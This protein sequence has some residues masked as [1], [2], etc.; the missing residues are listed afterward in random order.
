LDTYTTASPALDQTQ[1]TKEQ[2]TGFEGIVVSFLI[3]GNRFYTRGMRIKEEAINNAAVE[4]DWRNVKH[5][6][7][8]SYQSI[9]RV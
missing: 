1:L 9:P 7:L 6:N 8:S 2:A 3:A 4:S 5:T